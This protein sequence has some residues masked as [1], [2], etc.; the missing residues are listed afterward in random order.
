MNTSL[1]WAYIAIGMISK[2]LTMKHPTPGEKLIVLPVI[3]TGA[4]IVAWLIPRDLNT[5]A[6]VVLTV[7]HGGEIAG[8]WISQGIDKLRVLRAVRSVRAKLSQVTNGGPAK[9]D[10]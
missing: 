1:F 7:F 8:R 2:W 3:F 4:L 6:I 5:A 10:G 9:A